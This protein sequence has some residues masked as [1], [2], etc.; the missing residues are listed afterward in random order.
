[1]LR[2]RA[3][4]CL[5]LCLAIIHPLAYLFKLH[6]FDKGGISPHRK[7]SIERKRVGCFVFI[8]KHANK[9][10]TLTVLTPRFT[11]K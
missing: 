8:S 5:L 4:G 7:K 9:L 3:L 6:V 10:S 2:S 11:G 1:M